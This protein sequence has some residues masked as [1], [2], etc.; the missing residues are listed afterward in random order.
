MYKLFQHNLL[1]STPHIIHKPYPLH[2]VGCLSFFRNPG[3]GIEPRTQNQTFTFKK[4]LPA[5]TLEGLILLNNLQLLDNG[6][7]TA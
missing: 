4:S 6:S 1:R 7:N 2:L 3:T 5:K